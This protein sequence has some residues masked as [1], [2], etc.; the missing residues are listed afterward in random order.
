MSF[1]PT[2]AALTAAGTE[3]VRQ[4]PMSPYAF[5]AISLASFL[6]LLGV[7][8][9]FRNTAARYDTPIR[10]QHGSPGDHGAHS[11]PGSPGAAEPGAHH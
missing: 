10:V 2:V 3:Q 9:S 8:W 5:G 4:L 11:G 6:M 1:M 7:L